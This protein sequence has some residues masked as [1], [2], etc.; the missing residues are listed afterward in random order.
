MEINP[1]AKDY[2]IN[3][4]LPPYVAS[5]PPIIEDFLYMD[6]YLFEIVYLN[7]EFQQLY[8]ICH[9]MHNALT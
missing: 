4:A 9:T 2:H 8:K 1:L 7:W 6:S 3:K 5:N